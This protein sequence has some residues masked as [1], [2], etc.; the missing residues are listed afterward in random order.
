V[1]Q[2]FIFCPYCGARAVKHKLYAADGDQYECRQCPFTA[3]TK[4]PTRADLEKLRMLQ[5]KNPG[6]RMVHI[7]R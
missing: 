6:M 1:S 2:S 5:D 3:A 4:S 7:S